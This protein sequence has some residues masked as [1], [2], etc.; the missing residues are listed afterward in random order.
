[1]F[2]LLIFLFAVAAGLLFG[3]SLTPFTILIAGA[4]AAL[5]FA[6]GAFVTAKRQRSVA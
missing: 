4:A 2:V 5:I 1:M 6:L 3:A